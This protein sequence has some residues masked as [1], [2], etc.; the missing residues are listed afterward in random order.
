MAMSEVLRFTPWLETDDRV[1]ET[2]ELCRENLPIFEYHFSPPDQSGDLGEEAHGYCCLSCGQQLLTNLEML[3]IARWGQDSRAS[4][5]SR[6]LESLWESPAVSYVLDSQLRF[7]YCNPAWD[8]FANS[9][10]APELSADSVVGTDLFDVI[11]DSLRPLYSAAFANVLSTSRVWEQP[12]ECSSPAQFR[13]FCMRIHLLRPRN[14][15]LVTN[16]LVFERDHPRVAAPDPKLYVSFDNSITTCVHCRWSHR[17]DGS[18]QWDFVPEYLRLDP[19]SGLHIKQSL[20]PIC[21]AYFF[22][23][24]EPTP[25]AQ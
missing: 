13:V 21:G 7:V 18:D 5:A 10:D 23:R 16:A 24:Q 6:T 4:Q 8:R 14:W 2:C 12:Y 20:C 15:F 3:T 9:N 11:P 25:P 1:P 19:D 22:G 17:V